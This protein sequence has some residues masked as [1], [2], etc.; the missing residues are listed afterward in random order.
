MKTIKNLIFSALILFFAVGKPMAQ[1]NQNFQIPEIKNI[2]IDGK[3]EDWK[4][5]GFKINILASKNGYFPPQKDFCPKARVAWNSQGLCLLFEVKDDAIKVSENTDEL[6]LKD[7][8]EFFV[9]SPLKSAEFFQVV[10][11]PV[12][13][14]DKSK[15]KYK[16]YDFRGIPDP[17]PDLKIDVASSRSN[18]GYI[19]EAL[20][21]WSNFTKQPGPGAEIGF[22]VMIDDV[23]ENEDRFS[24]MWYPDDNTFMNSSLVYGLMLAQKP[25]APF[26]SVLRFSQN[27]SDG[28]KINA[29]CSADMA[30]KKAELKSGKISLG[31]KKLALQDGYATAGFDLVFPKSGEEYKNLTLYIDGKALAYLNADEVKA[32]KIALQTYSELITKGGFMFG[33]DAKFPIYD[34]KNHENMKQ[35]YGDYKINTI[36]YDKNFN[37][38]DIAKANGRYG[39]VCEIVPQYG[40][41]FKRFVTCAKFP[42]TFYGWY[43][44][45]MKDF[46]MHP[47][48]VGIDSAKFN[49]ANENNNYRVVGT[50]LNSMAEDPFG[51]SYMASMCE[52]SMNSASKTKSYDVITVDRQWWVD[53]KRKYYGAD[54]IFPS[55]YVC[56]K[57]IEG[58]PA[59]ELKF[60]SPEEA[61][62][63]PV[64]VKQIDSICILWSANSDQAFALCLARHGV[65]YLYKAYGMRDGINMTVDTKSWMAS[66]TKL[67]GGCIGMGFVDQGIISL[68][69]PIDKYLVEFKDV[70]VAKPITIR[71]LYTH[72]AGFTGDHWGDFINDY[73][74]RVLL[75]YPSMEVGS[76]YVYSGADLALMGKLLERISGEA[77]PLLFQNHLLLPLNCNNT[78][79]TNA[80]GDARSVPLDYAKIGQ[81]LLNKGAYGRW[82]F[83]SENTY[84]QMLPQ[85]LTKTL[86]DAAVTEYGIGTQWFKDEGWGKG[87]FAHGSATSSVLRIDPENDMVVCI[88][89]NDAGSNYNTYYPLFVK[90][91]MSAIKK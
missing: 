82:R 17:K 79:V 43:M 22:Q 64:A 78:L 65:I 32:S 49:K 9:C 23:D 75:N 46:R 25:S 70:K 18:D 87:T 34:F 47:E 54:M 2:L 44:A 26:N 28:I 39:G 36:W 68:D 33:Q 84:E 59:R 63:D 41:P 50:L 66:L 38:A 77:L 80:S 58:A 30:N 37:K 24:M 19:V 4:E 10:I 76:K 71:H 83:F 85:R 62:M 14:N 21:P 27:N 15:P 55:P 5:N 57:P 6:F 12:A 51:S 61:G 3:S 1:I 88:T 69:D 31:T 20:V 73:E 72:T 90:A 42:E 8:V 40:P 48:A 29:T 11:G 60:G 91:V 52:L 13:S 53:F 35:L 86:G 89:R 56:P 74:E 16:L 67:I 81:M 7:A 45:M